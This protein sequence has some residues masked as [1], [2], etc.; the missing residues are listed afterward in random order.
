MSPASLG[1]PAS[2]PW[3]RAMPMAVLSAALLAGCQLSGPAGQP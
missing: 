3:L 2:G 1:S